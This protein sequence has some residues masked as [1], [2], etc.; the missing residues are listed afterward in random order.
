MQRHFTVSCRRSRRPGAKAHDVP[1]RRRPPAPGAFT[2]I[3]LLVVVAI[4][5]VLVSVLLPALQGAREQGRRAL[6]AANERQ[7]AG[8]LL[9]YAFGSNDQFPPFYGLYLHNLMILTGPSYDSPSYPSTGLHYMLD[10]VEPYMGGGKVLECPSGKAYTYEWGIAAPY[11]P[12]SSGFYFLHAAYGVIPGFH[13]SAGI[14]PIWYD[15][16][17]E[18][19]T[20]YQDLDGI[21][22]ASPAATPITLDFVWSYASDGSPETPGRGN[23]DAAGGTLPSATPPGQNNGYLDGHVRWVSLSQMRPAWRN[24][25]GVYAFW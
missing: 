7:I 23:H 2:L 10:V 9:N 13:S 22:S 12:S 16:P 14:S 19:M 21:D 25:E 24:H 4:I 3:E 1:V 18:G 20:A 17:V 15:H 8:G 11:G 6:C 5:A